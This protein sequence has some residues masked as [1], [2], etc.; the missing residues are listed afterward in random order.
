MIARACGAAQPS[1]APSRRHLTVATEYSE[2]TPH[3]A[4]HALPAAPVR[5]AARR[6]ARPVAASVSLPENESFD[7]ALVDSFMT[8]NLRRMG[9]PAASVAVVHRDYIVHAAGYGTRSDGG[10]MTA[11]TVM[12]IAS[13]TK[14]FT[15]LAD[16]AGQRIGPD[17]WR[18]RHSAGT[19]LDAAAGHGQLRHR[20]PALPALCARNVAASCAAGPAQRGEPWR[21]RALERNH[22]RVAAAADS[23]C[24]DV[25]RL[26]G[27]AGRAGNARREV[28]SLCAHLRP[29]PRGRE[30]QIVLGKRIWCS[31]RFSNSRLLG[32]TATILRSRPACSPA[33]CIQYSCG[34]PSRGCSQRTGKRPTREAGLRGTYIDSPRPA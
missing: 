34:S 4:T 29:M 10:P 14:S 23:D 16:D 17:G 20:N 25:T 30:P 22:C 6:V 19:T 32:A 27:T 26:G 15:A 21:G 2:R 9:V 7:P 18:G 3:A 31:R 1:L 33:R 24:G 11:D 5:R 13:L 12:P 8:E 28:A